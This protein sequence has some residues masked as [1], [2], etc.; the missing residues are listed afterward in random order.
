MNNFYT[1]HAKEYFYFCNRINSKRIE[2]I[3]VLFNNYQMTL[4]PNLLL[5]LWHDLIIYEFHV[6]SRIVGEWFSNPIIHGILQIVIQVLTWHPRS[7][8][9]DGCSHHG[10]KIL[11]ITSRVII[12]RYFILLMIFWLF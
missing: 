2:P 10:R 12:N 8:F 11:A 3:T 1:N 7:P 9:V 4:Q 5:G 6:S